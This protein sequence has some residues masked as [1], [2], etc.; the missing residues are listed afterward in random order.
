MGKRIEQVRAAGFTEQTISRRFVKIVVEKQAR[1]K[2]M[3][4]YT[5]RIQKR[6]GAHSSQ[7]DQPEFQ[8]DI[9][10]VEALRE[11]PR[12]TVDSNGRLKFD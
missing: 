3:E 5:R 6:L 9:S 1:A 12:F 10:L 4:R 11:T 2:R 7:P 8:G